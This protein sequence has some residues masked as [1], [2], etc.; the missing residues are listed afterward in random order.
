MLAV[1]WLEGNLWVSG[2]SGGI[3]SP[4]ASIALSKQ[5]T[6]GGRDGLGR[7]L[8]KQNS[9]HC[10]RN[11]IA[12]KDNHY[13]NIQRLLE[14]EH[15]TQTGKSLTPTPYSPLPTLKIDLIMSI[16]GEALL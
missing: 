8:R 7:F 5:S 15:T 2:I 12:K 14:R 13:R 1:L 3:S 9:F 11:Q 6:I 4:A 16:L 10:Q